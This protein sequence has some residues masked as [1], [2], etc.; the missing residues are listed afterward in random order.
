MSYSATLAPVSF[1][2]LV[3]HHRLKLLV[4]LTAAAAVAACIKTGASPRIRHIFS[5]EFA[6]TRDAA[7]A[8][9]FDLPFEPLFGAG[10][11]GNIFKSQSKPVR[12]GDCPLGNLAR[13]AD[14]KDHYPIELRRSRVDG[15]QRDHYGNS[16]APARDVRLQR[17]PQLFQIH[18]GELEGLARGDCADF[19]RSRKN[20]R[21]G[22]NVQG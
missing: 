3:I 6:L 21:R 22:K 13:T 9:S 15:H 16:S 17:H 14:D 8:S 5:R 19:R 10:W 20:H 2:H 1:N 12:N 7:A 4:Y 11:T 18:R